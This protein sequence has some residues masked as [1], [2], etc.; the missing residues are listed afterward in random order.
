M[1]SKEQLKVNAMMAAR[2]VAGAFTRKGKL[3]AVRD[4]LAYLR[5]SLK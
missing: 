2:R 3:A 1:A 4:C 5:E